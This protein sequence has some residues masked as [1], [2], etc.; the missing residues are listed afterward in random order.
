LTT[1]IM[2]RLTTK[3][4]QKHFSY[5]VRL[6]TAW[7]NWRQ[8]HGQQPYRLNSDLDWCWLWYSEYRAIHPCISAVYFWAPRG[9]DARCRRYAYPVIVIYRQSGIEGW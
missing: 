5:R 1:D 3:R 2:R 9:G 7:K 4:L 8:H 6:K